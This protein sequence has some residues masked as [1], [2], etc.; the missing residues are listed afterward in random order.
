MATPTPVAP[1]PTTIMSHGLGW[2]SIRRHISVRFMAAFRCKCLRGG[3]AIPRLDGVLRL[4]SG[5]APPRHHTAGTHLRRFYPVKRARDCLFPEVI[6]PFARLFIHRRLPPFIDCPVG[7]EFI[8][9]AE[10]AY[11][12][13]GRVGC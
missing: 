4:R 1:P 2:A 10:E 13:S 7:D 8:G 11:R 3:G 5:Q 9:I 12:Q 6:K